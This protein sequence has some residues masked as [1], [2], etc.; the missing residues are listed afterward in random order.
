M[1]LGAPR[2]IFRPRKNVFTFS[3]KKYIYSVAEYTQGSLTPIE[4]D[5]LNQRGR[6]SKSDLL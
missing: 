4:S 6:E 5:Y 1:C 2:G 3:G